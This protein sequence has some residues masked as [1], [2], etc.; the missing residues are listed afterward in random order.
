MQ[1][2]FYGLL[3][4]SAK[5]HKNRSLQFWVISF[6]SWCV[7]LRHSV[8]WNVDF[9]QGCWADV[10]HRSRRQDAT[11]RSSSHQT[12]IDTISAQ[13]DVLSCLTTVRW[14]C[15]LRVQYFSITFPAFHTALNSRSVSYRRLLPILHLHRHKLV[16]R[17][18]I[19]LSSY[20][21]EVSIKGWI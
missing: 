4:I 2:I 14:S 11:M 7:F 19:G 15:E 9:G 10:E 21:L 13:S 8:V 20:F 16:R 1:T 6:Q 17:R 12:G 5:C 3:N 18:Y